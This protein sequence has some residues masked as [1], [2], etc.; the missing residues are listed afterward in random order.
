MYTLIEPERIFHFFDDVETVNEMLNLILLT[1]V[2]ELKS[3]QQIYNSGDYDKTRKTC[4]KSKPTMLYLGASRMKNSLE[5]LER[6]IP[7]KFNL[8][9]PVFL[10]ELILLETEVKA[11]LKEVNSRAF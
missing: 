4:H 11:F 6:N 9:Y 2:E 10:E 5:K 7:E 8:L 1:N 3:L